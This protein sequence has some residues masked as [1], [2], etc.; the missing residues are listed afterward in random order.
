MSV[1]KRNRQ[2][3]CATSRGCDYITVIDRHWWPIICQGCFGSLLATLECTASEENRYK[4]LQPHGSNFASNARDLRSNACAFSDT[5]AIGALV[6]NSCKTWSRGMVSYLLSIDQIL[7]TDRLRSRPQAGL[8]RIS[9]SSSAHLSVVLS[10]RAVVRGATW[11]LAVRI[12]H[13]VPGID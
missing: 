5:R 13:C 3:P 4:W 1:V 7:G 11:K 9:I 6:I 10:A 12:A 8:L 2:H